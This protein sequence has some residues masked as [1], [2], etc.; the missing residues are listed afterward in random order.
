MWT[1]PGVVSLSLLLSTALLWSALVSTALLWSVL[2]ST[3]LPWSVLVSTAIMWSV[4]VSTA[5]LWSVPVSTALLWSVLVSTAILWSVQVS[6]VLLWSVPVYYTSVVSLSP[7]HFCGVSRSPVYFRGVSWFLLHFCGVPCLYHSWSPLHFCGVLHVPRN[8]TDTQ[9]YLQCWSLQTV[10]ISQSP[11]IMKRS[12]P[13]SLRPSA[14]L[15]STMKGREGEALLW[16]STA[17]VSGKT[18]CPEVCFLQLV[19]WQHMPL[20]HSCVKAL[21]SQS[22]K[23]FLGGW[24]PLY[25]GKKNQLLHCGHSLEKEGIVLLR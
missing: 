21:C 8:S 17:Y 13:P 19:Q 22:L 11:K 1:S 5:S 9:L 4:P 7:L 20:K 16:K 3:A 18:L 23:K 12:L 6:S 10:S 14:T 25:N 24:V 2:V 15:K